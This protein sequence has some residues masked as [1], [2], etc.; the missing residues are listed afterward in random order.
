[1][2]A[3]LGSSVLAGPFAGIS[4]VP[5]F[6]REI[7]CPVL[8]L[9]GLY[10]HFLNPVLEEQIAARPTVIANIGCADGYSCG[11]TGPPPA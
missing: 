9:F 5:N 11:G 10:E 2:S 1:M 7:A 6:E 3:H 4:L 8:K